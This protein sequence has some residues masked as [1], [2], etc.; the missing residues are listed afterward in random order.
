MADHRECEFRV[1]AGDLLRGQRS[2]LAVPGR[3]RGA[4]GDDAASG[5]GRKRRLEPAPFDA[6]AYRQVKEVHLMI[7]LGQDRAAARLLE[8]AQLAVSQEALLLPLDVAQD[9]N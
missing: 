3:H 8:A 7:A 9:M 6:I 1:P 5:L 2:R 4:H